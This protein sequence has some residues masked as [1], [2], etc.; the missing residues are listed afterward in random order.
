M[1]ILIVHR[2]IYNLEYIQFTHIKQLYYIKTV[3]PFRDSVLP[4]EGKQNK[5]TSVNTTINRH[6]II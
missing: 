6:I 4:W 5:N 2:E 1:L 3:N